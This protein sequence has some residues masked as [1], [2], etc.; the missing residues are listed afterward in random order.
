[1]KIK[2]L[3]IAATALVCITACH[4]YRDDYMVEDTVYL[5][6]ATDALVQD[7]SVYD[8]LFR[9]G[10]IKSGKGRTGDN[11]TIGIAPT[12]SVLKYNER[13]STNFV[14]LSKSLYNAEE[15]DNKVL[16]FA[17]NDARIKVDVKWDPAAM[18]SKMTA[19]TDNFVIPV[20]IKKASL[21]VSKTKYM[22]LIHPVLSTIGVR[23]ADNAMT[24]KALSTFTGKIGVVL[25]NPISTHDVKVKLSYTPAAATVNGLDYAA[26]PAGAINLVS[27]EAVIKAGNTEV[28]IEVDLDMNKVAEGVDRVAGKVKIE[29]VTVVTADGGL[30]IMPI[31]SDEMVVR[32]TKTKK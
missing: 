15:I 4:D 24:C 30:D 32:V 2:Y 9:F 21:A 5:R 14:P 3:L 12:D 8:A 31:R 17:Q 6:S 11:V 16:E 28:D 18:V 29:S 27:D 25:D 20:F 26:A 22:V 19:E 1:M 23:E 10:V 13:H 7:Y